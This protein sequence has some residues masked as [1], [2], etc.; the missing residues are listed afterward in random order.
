MK[1]IK[2]TILPTTLIPAFLVAIDEA[3]PDEQI[4]LAIRLMLG[5]GL[6]HSEICELRWTQFQNIESDCLYIPSRCEKGYYFPVPGALAT[7]LV[8]WRDEA[9]ADRA[10]VQ[11]EVPT[12]VFITPTG[13]RRSPSF[14]RR[15]I[16]TACQAIGWHGQVGVTLLRRTFVNLLF[17]I[18]VCSPGHFHSYRSLQSTANYSYISKRKE[19]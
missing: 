6:R 7:E 4:R 9:I 13:D 11:Q 15:V 2:E 18:G 8:R 14:A 10:Q 3:T 19:K 5:L 16:K 12:L 1:T 17:E